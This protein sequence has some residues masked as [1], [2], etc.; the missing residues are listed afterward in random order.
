MK[1]MFDYFKDAQTGLASV[2]SLLVST[3]CIWLSA[4][5]KFAGTAI[6]GPEFFGLTSTAIVSQ[7]E[8]LDPDHRCSLYWQGKQV[9]DCHSSA[10]LTKHCGP[11]E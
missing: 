2:E 4:T 9:I 1:Q 8:E 6:P 3:A 10:L 11:L 7:I 5:F